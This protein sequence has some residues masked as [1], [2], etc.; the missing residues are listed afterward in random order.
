VLKVHVSLFI[1]VLLPGV[2]FG[3][4]VSTSTEFTCLDEVGRSTGSKKAFAGRPTTR[5]GQDVFEFSDRTGDELF[6]LRSKQPKG[7]KVLIVTKDGMFSV[8]SPSPAVNL[9]ITLGSDPKAK[10]FYYQSH[11]FGTEVDTTDDI[12]NLLQ[13]TAQFSAKPQDGKPIGK[14]IV[15]SEI[16]TDK[17]REW[18]YELALNYAKNN[19]EFLE[20]SMEWRGMREDTISPEQM[21]GNLI[22]RY[23]L[24]LSALEK[25]GKPAS[26]GRE[27]L[28]EMVAQDLNYMKAINP[29]WKKEPE[30]QREA[31]PAPAVEK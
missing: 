12:K 15:A 17:M 16:T 31:T 7:D 30:S 5:I 23:E 6:V 19:R 1:L 28:R 24:C 9:P 10:T 20:K 26:K 25:A 29:K 8:N 27:Q 18:A 22:P 14:K 13:D 21:A 11:A 3:K 4:P 2:V